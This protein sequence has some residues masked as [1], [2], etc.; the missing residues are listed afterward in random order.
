MREDVFIL[1]AFCSRFSNDMI[2]IVCVCR[3]SKAKHGMKM[4]YYGLQHGGNGSTFGRFLHGAS[5]PTRAHYSIS[6]QLV[7]IL[8]SCTCCLVEITEYG[9]VLQKAITV[10]AEKW[11]L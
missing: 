5:F 2:F 3:L 6:F 8:F 10:G 11:I 1:S 7:F 9:S 4:N